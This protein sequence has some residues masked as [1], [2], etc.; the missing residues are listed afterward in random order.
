MPGSMESSRHSGSKN[1]DDRGQHLRP[2]RRRLPEAVD[3]SGLQQ[4]LAAWQRLI[5]IGGDGLWKH[6]SSWWLGSA[7]PIGAARKALRV[8][9][10]SAKPRCGC[11]FERFHRANALSRP[12]ACR[13]V[14]LQQLYE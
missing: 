11:R 10:G 1:R 4:A 12:G 9:A 14:A 8:R 2:I 6:P 3:L 5:V 7:G 13:I